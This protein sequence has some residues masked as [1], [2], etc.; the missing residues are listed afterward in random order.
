MSASSRATD[1]CVCATPFNVCATNICVTKCTLSS[2]KISML[3]GLCATEKLF[4][5]TK[6]DYF[7]QRKSCL[8]DEIDTSSRKLLLLH[9]CISPLQ[10]QNAKKILKNLSVLCCATVSA[11]NSI[12]SLAQCGVMY[13]VN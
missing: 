13:E 2:H 6:N 7:M 10:S 5:S 9:I 3:I 11:G 8:R 1:I 12:R 4:C